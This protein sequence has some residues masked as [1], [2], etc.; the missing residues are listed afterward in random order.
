MT[1]TKMTKKVIDKTHY[2]LILNVYKPLQMSTFYWYNVPSC[3]LTLDPWN[4]D[5]KKANYLLP[6]YVQTYKPI[7][8]TIYLGNYFSL[9]VR[10]IVQYDLDNYSEL[11]WFF[12]SVCRMSYIKY[13]L[14]AHEFLKSY[15]INNHLYVVVIFFWGPM[16]ALAY[17]LPFQITNGIHVSA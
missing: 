10:E 11:T 2:Q 12:T 4:M 8:K 5:R 15:S 16:K 1:F 3:I 7:S 6:V 14:S 13:T 17:S 9:R